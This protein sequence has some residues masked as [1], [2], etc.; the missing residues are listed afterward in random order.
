MS[1]HDSDVCESSTGYDHLDQS[2]PADEVRA[3]FKRMREG[4]CPLTHSPHHGGFD[5]VN[6]H[7]DVR[8]V[9]EDPQT[10]SSGADG[11]FIPGGDLPSI[12]ALEFDEPEHTV[13]RE[14]LDGPLNP[15]AVR[16]FEPTIVEIAD[17]LID[18]FAATGAADLATQLA[19]PLPAIVIG[20][21]VGLDQ[22][23]AVVVRAIAVEMAA[24]IGTPEFP[25]KQAPFVAFTEERLAERRANPREDY[26]TRLAAGAVAGVELDAGGVAGVLTAYLLG[27]HHS[28]ALGIAGL[29]RHALEIPGL[30]AE[31]T[32]DRKV[33]NRAI[34][35][36]LR[37]T[38]PLQLFA[39]TATTSTELAGVGLEAG[40]RVM[41]NL[42]AANRDP[43]VFAD[44]E[45]FDLTRPRNPHLAFGAGLHGCQGQHLARA[46]MR[47]ALQR[48]VQRLPD[49]RLDGPVVE[50]GMSSGL[51][52][53][54]VSLPVAFT[55][56]GA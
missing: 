56:E 18:E 40:A 10:Y 8:A 24:A 31:A 22:D 2:V 55:P 16:A 19:E 50:L 11:V 29:L 48:L 32:A 23:E 6:R 51:L 39:R 35:E 1:I 7:V 45:E 4:G 41:L 30:A 9:L 44:P 53:P 36:S 28:T 33:L 38:T 13:W 12:P 17:L 49:I 3:L 47:V 42:G 20:R 15:G 34:E 43:R 37:L 46:E 14:V 54:I 52:Q 21:M 5:Y 25:E 26:L 27:G